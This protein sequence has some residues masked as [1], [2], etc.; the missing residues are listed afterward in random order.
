MP[1]TPPLLVTGNVK[2][3]LVP[4]RFEK[5]PSATFDA[6]RARGRFFEMLDV[7]RLTRLDRPSL[8]SSLHGTIGRILFTIPGW[9]FTP[10]SFP[11]EAELVRRYAAAFRSLLSTLP[12]SCRVVLFTHAGTVSHAQAW[13]DEFN[14]SGR[15]EIVSAPNAMNFTVWAE[16]AYCVCRDEADAETYLVEPASFTRSD[17]ALIAD[18][19]A[20][21]TDLESTQVQLYFQGGNVLIGDDFWFIGADY[22]IHS[23]DLGFIEPAAGESVAQAVARGYGSALDSRRRLI[24]LGSRVPVPAQVRRPITIQGEPWHEVLHFG[25]AAGTLQPLFHIDMFVSLAGKVD[26]ER[27]TVLVGDP[28]LAAD[29]LGEPLPD[30]AMVDVFNDIAIGLDEL[31]FSVVRTPLPMAYDDDDSGNT[32]F[33]YFATGNNVLAQDNPRKVWIPSYGHGPW[34]KLAATDALNAQIWRQ[35]GYDVEMLPDFHP[36]A[37]NLGAAHCIKKYLMRT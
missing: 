24:V 11:S 23:L 2:S 13:L 6:F 17:D 3:K 15:S 21:K 37:A 8:I 4:F 27:Y 36:F 30:G 5:D 31:G 18:R 35:L 28:Q 1:N 12:T 14:M 22:P 10:E 25:N 20:P 19:I 7:D 32:R 9:V 33:W 29:T 16:D 26:G 34:A